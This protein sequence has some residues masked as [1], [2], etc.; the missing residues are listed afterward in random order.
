MRDESEVV[1]AVVRDTRIDR[2]RWR[3]PLA[4]CA[5][6]TPR[7]REVLALLRPRLTDA[8]IAAQLAISRRT[9][10]THVA[11]ILGKLG[12]ANRREAAA[13]AARHDID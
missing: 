5:R 11:N 13:I 8:E 6:L 2:L 10:A 7:E 4:P 1:M 12:A 9:V 3:E